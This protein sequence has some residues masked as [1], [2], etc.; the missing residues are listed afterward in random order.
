MYQR[1]SYSQSHVSLPNG[2]SQHASQIVD[3]FHADEG[4]HRIRCTKRLLRS[5]AQSL[6]KRGYANTIRV[7]IISTEGTTPGHF[8]TSTAQNCQASRFHPRY[9][10]RSSPAILY[11][12][13]SKAT[14]AHDQ[15]HQ[16]IA[17]W[18]HRPSTNRYPPRYFAQ[19]HLARS[20]VNESYHLH[21]FC[22]RSFIS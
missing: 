19:N 11:P 3:H 21:R 9:Q 8:S 10:R 12:N 16:T 20:R 15:C 1:V 13:G 2:G 22:F 6:S 5:T 4:N 14:V 18:S 7:I 17:K